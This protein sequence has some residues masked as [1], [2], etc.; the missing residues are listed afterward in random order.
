[1][2]APERR[3]DPIVA[4]ERGDDDI[5]DAGIALHMARLARELDANL[6]KLRRKRCI[7]D[8]LGTYTWHGDVAPSQMDG[9]DYSILRWPPQRVQDLPPVFFR[10]LMMM[11]ISGT[12]SSG[13]TA[14]KGWWI[15]PD[16]CGLQRSRFQLEGVDRRI[17]DFAGEFLRSR[18][19]GR[20]DAIANTAAAIAKL[21]APRIWLLL[22]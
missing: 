10:F 1:M 14:F 20:L 6:V 5:S 11:V 22:K 3:V 13:S 9:L 12:I 21:T 8:R 16:N 17:M 19:V 18:P 7:Q 2:L 15:I 4:I